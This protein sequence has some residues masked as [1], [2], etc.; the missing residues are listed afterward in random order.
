MTRTA[1]AL[2]LFLVS[3][4]ALLVSLPAAADVLVMVDGSQIET[5]GP[6]EVRGRQ[7]RFRL[8]NG[9]LSSVRASEVDLAASEEA[10]QAATRP[11]PA[12]VEAPEP[13]PVLVLT[14]KDIGRASAEVIQEADTAA[15]GA[16]VQVQDWSY[17]RLETDDPAYELVGT[18]R[19]VGTTPVSGLSLYVDITGVD[20][21]GS[22]VTARNM[23]REV[24]IDAGELEA[25]ESTDFRYAI[26]RSDLFG[27][28][29]PEQFVNPQVNFDVRFE[30]VAVP[31]ED[32]ELPGDED[33]GADEAGTVDGFDTEEEP[34]FEEE[35]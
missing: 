20:E 15:A 32:G 31:A 21:G 19:N 8:P 3:I 30:E 18:L 25:G 29:A 5:D 1:R 7:I 13:E 35:G 16:N 9:T 34:D 4:P 6:W 28:G 10:T 27:S 26:S 33:V 2:L 24:Q 22:G 11:A 17:N 12:P 23:L 14:D